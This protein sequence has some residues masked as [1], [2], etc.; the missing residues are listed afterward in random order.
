M[1]I[2]DWSSD[3]CSSDLHRRPPQRVVDEVFEADGAIG[4]G[5]GDRV[6]DAELCLHD[7]GR[8]L[9]DLERPG[10]G[11]PRLPIDPDR[12]APH[13][14]CVNARLLRNRTGGV[15]GSL[16]EAAAG[17]GDRKSVAWGKSVSVRLRLGCG[18]L[19]IKKNTHS[20]GKT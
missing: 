8:R 7:G 12:D 5:A 20:I 13:G 17:K 19:L 16:V 9:T 18:C 11:F 2:S 1:R 10:D 14:A 4:E 3:V 6:A 15:D